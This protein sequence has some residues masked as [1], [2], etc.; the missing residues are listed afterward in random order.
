MNPKDLFS[1]CFSAK[2]KPPNSA[3]LAHRPLWP[4]MQETVG[5]PDQ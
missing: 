5:F 3:L 4:I 1:S 2:S